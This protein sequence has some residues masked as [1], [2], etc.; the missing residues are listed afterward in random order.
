MEKNE[1]KKLV[2]VG[3]TS[4]D[5]FYPT[6]CSCCNLMQLYR[7]NSFLNRA[8]RKFVL[9]SDLPGKKL[10]FNKW[11]ER[12]KE[13]DAVIV[14]ETGNVI[15]VVKWI[16]K[17]FPEKKVIIWYR[18]PVKKTVPI[19]KEMTDLGAEIWSFDP[20]DCKQYGLRYN[21]QFFIREDIKY[22]KTDYSNHTDV[23]FIGT[24][25][26]RSEMLKEL[27]SLF[28]EK[29]ILYDFHLV[30]YKGSKNDGGIQYKEPLQYRDVLSRVASSKAV[31]DLVSEGQA[32]LTRRPIE[33][34]LSKKKLI[35]NMK[36]IVDFK[37]Y[38][39][40]NTFVLGVDDYRDLADF[41]DSP[42]NEDN[43]EELCEYYL[44]DAWLERFDMGI[45][46][47]DY[48]KPTE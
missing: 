1:T 22:F 40:N 32:G 2:L 21:T 8:V 20:S 25:K 7:S 30:R 31:L 35:T 14:F 12:V 39:P 19:T 34:L 48:R 18:N 26:N 23:F 36:S 44:M 47:F 37:I 3:K 10:A 45:S 43:Y 38:N 27:A 33:A 46:W 28:D 4:A 13:S 24:D 42:F 5:G 6:E 29:G 41:I 16:R 15:G 11:I 9:T 17:Y